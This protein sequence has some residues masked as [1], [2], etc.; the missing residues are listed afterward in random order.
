MGQPDAKKRA[1]PRAAAKKSTGNYAKKLAVK[2]KTEMASVVD[3][4]F[5]EV[6]EYLDKALAYSD[7][8]RGLNDPAAGRDKSHLNALRTVHPSPVKDFL[9][10][11]ASE[12]RSSNVMHYAEPIS[13]RFL[14]A[15][16]TA[17]G[18]K[19]VRA[20]L[21]GEKPTSTKFAQKLLENLE[22]IAINY[23]K[24][25]ASGDFSFLTQEI[26]PGEFVLNDDVKQQVTLFAK[27]YF[28]KHWRI[29]H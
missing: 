8:L 24:N 14:G 4:A 9:E 5:E 25:P 27:S 26:S 22:I 23:R 21:E 7:K 10:G 18:T 29:T 3:K 13:R 20:V 2:A 11:C 28:K 19:P 12:A 6:S 16:T 15:F 1:K 17:L